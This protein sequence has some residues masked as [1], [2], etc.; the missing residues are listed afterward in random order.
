M[1]ET[2][3]TFWN[4]KLC[5]TAALLLVQKVLPL[6]IIRQWKTDTFRA[7]QW[8]A[9]LIMS[10]FAFLFLPNSLLLESGGNVCR[11]GGT[12]KLTHAMPHLWAANKQRR[13]PRCSVCA[14]AL[15]I[16]TPS[17]AAISQVSNGLFF[18][19]DEDTR[20]HAGSPP[21]Q[22]FIAISLSV[23]PSHGF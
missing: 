5:K 10:C 9:P 16:V 2:S 18:R 8:R 12:F 17:S 22:L 13:Q 21:D 14:S 11:I 3:C 6:P 15:K 7:E 4:H 20:L 19:F 1:M 23:R